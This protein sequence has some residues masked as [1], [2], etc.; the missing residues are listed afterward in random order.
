M[1]QIL[2]RTHLVLG[3][4][5]L[6]ADVDDRALG[7]ERGGDAGDRVGAA[8]TGGGDDAAELAGLARIAIGR[9]RGHLLVPHVDDADAFIDAAVVDVDDVAAAEREDRVDAFVLERLRHQMAARHD[10]RVTALLLQRVFGRGR[11]DWGGTGLTL[12]ISPPIQ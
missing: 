5:A 7:A 11:F 1:R 2:Q 8:G 9:V 12:A 10:A 6:A 3:E 4:R